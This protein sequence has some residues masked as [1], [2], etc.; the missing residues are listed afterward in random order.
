[1][2]SLDDDD[3]DHSEPSK[4]LAQPEWHQLGALSLFVG[5]PLFTFGV[6]DNGVMIICGDQIVRHFGKVMSTLAAA[7][8]GNWISD[9]LGLG[10]GAVFHGTAKKLGFS[11]GGITA[12]QH[13][14]PI[15]QATILAAMFVGISL[16][17]FLGMVPLLF[18]PNAAPAQM[19]AQEQ[20]ELPKRESLKQEAALDRESLKQ[21][22]VLDRYH[23][24]LCTLL[25][26]GTI[27][28]KQREFADKFREQNAIAEDI[29]VDLCLRLGWTKLNWQYGR[30]PEIPVEVAVSSAAVGSSAVALVTPPSKRA[31]AD[32]AAGG[33]AQ[34]DAAK[35][36]AGPKAEAKASPKAKAE[37]K[38]GKSD[39]AGDNAAGGPAQAVATNASAGPV[40]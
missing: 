36:P 39:A 33:P 29:H 7:G 14:L 28:D 3:Y 38:K 15:T 23:W 31:P 37:G 32:N 21:E 17:C 9:I 24:I 6:V 10:F 12:A 18:M 4:T 34:A 40:S 25:T 35:A 26:D 8:I 11:D 30:G 19:T 5:I 22:A 1:M 16:G 20:A 13:E 27:D 2:I